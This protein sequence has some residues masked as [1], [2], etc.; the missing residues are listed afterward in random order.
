MTELLELFSQG[1]YSD[2]LA[3]YATGVPDESRELLTCKGISHMR[4][5]D[6]D[7][8]KQVFR[9]LLESNPDDKE[10][11]IYMAAVGNSLI[12]NALDVGNQSLQRNDFDGAL[13]AY[14][15]VDVDEYTGLNADLVY[16][17]LNNRAVC[18]LNSGRPEEALAIF[19]HKSMV[20]C[21]GDT[22]E[23]M[24]QRRVDIHMNTAIVLKSLGRYEQ[25]LVAFQK[26]L[27]E[28]NRHMNALCGRAE[29]LNHLGRHDEALEVAA[30]HLE[31][32]TVPANAGLLVACG[33]ALMK[34]LRSDEALGLLQ[35]AVDASSSEGG[36]SSMAGAEALRL[37]G[38]CRAMQANSLLTG[39]DAAGALVIFDEVIA[40]TPPQQ[41]SSSTVFN[42]A[43]AHMQLGSAAGVAHPDALRHLDEAI[44]GYQQVVEQDANHFQGRVGLG[45]SLLLKADVA[46][47]TISS[48]RADLSLVL[49]MSLNVLQL[50]NG[51][52]HKWPTRSWPPRLL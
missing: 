19:E 11:L 35:R 42:R 37:R 48:F 4:T 22:S 29:V 2:F 51:Q 25:A 39:G 5:G 24:K 46:A 10:V 32:S 28:D 26:C 45:Q 1:K 12:H 50:R 49:L 18:L 3:K 33:F 52:R 43:L 30:P 27:S 6:V 20:A 8:A 41:L 16:Q 7:N 13:R 31:D 40:E 34:L 38:L 14:G 23:A 17:L 47:G 9:Q 36:A 15:K 21:T 44:S